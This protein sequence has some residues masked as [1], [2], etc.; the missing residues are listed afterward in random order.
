MTDRRWVNPSQPQTLY[1]G[2]VLLYLNAAF[3]VLL[4]GGLTAIGLGLVFTEV[5][6]AYGIANERRWGYLLGVLAASVG[7]LPFVLFALDDGLAELLAPSALLQMVF[8]VALFALLVHPMSRD[9]QKV[10]FS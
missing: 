6:G 2:T 5:A 7:L 4:S 9:Y 8:P 3:S 1:L 10:W